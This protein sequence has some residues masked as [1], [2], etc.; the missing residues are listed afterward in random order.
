MLMSACQG[1]GSDV[2]PLKPRLEAPF[3]LRSRRVAPALAGPQVAERQPVPARRVEGQPQ[4]RPA[5]MAGQGPKSRAAPYYPANRDA[6]R[7]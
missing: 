2:G 4:A 1:G 7:M 3:R 6:P 5:A